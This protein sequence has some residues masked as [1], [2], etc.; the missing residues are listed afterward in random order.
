MSQTID[1]DDFEVIVVKNFDEER[2]DAYIESNNMVN[3][4][5]YNES[6]QGEDVAMG[7]SKASGEVIC[8][9]DDDDLFENVKLARVYEEFASNRALSYYHNHRRFIDERGNS[10]KVKDTFR[11]KSRII[12]QNDGKAE[13]LIRKL[14]RSYGTANGSSI[15]VRR[16][17]IERILPLLP[18]A[19]NN[20]EFALFIS[21]ITTPGELIVDDKP[22][23]LYRVHSSW[24]RPK[25]AREDVLNRAKELYKSSMTSWEAIGQIHNITP[26]M[27]DS[28]LRK[29]IE[30]YS[31]KDRASYI[32]LNGQ[33][34]GDIFPLLHLA[35]RWNL[36]IRSAFL[37][38]VILMCLSYAVS[39]RMSRQLYAQAIC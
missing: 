14:F 8:L 5:H 9:L 20:I 37:S 32:L 13:P 36:K 12:L 39:P 25:G 19:Q 34:R 2:I 23:T 15:S 1:K 17:V 7:F 16:N 24:S 22:L 33:H 6:N 30:V 27:N 10:L 38:S 26:I 21:A 35:M 3:I 4:T 29:V 31:L 11:A 18:N 28:L